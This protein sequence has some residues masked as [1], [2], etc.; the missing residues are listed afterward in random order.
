MR[1]Q[2]AVAAGF[3]SMADLLYKCGNAPC[4]E[5]RYLLRRARC[6]V[7]CRGGASLIV[8]KTGRPVLHLA[9]MTARPYIARF[10]IDTGELE[11]PHDAL[12]AAHA[13]V[14]RA[15]VS[16][17]LSVRWSAITGLCCHSLGGWV[18]LLL[19]WRG[20]RVMQ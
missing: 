10:L 13:F 12:Y 5:N 16:P 14:P 17:V 1:T 11:L 18:A 8:T 15:R 2:V 7:L 19:R 9:C 3:T 20:E 4:R 6:A